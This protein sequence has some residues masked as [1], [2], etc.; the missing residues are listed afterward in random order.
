MWVDGIESP[1]KCLRSE[2]AG[3]FGCPVVVRIAIVQWVVKWGLHQTSKL[4]SKACFVRIY[5]ALS[6]PPL[7]P[8]V[9]EPYLSIVRE[10][11][12]IGIC[13]KMSC[14]RMGSI[15]WNSVACLQH[16]AN[17]FT[18]RYS[19]I[20]SKKSCLLLRNVIKLRSLSA[21]SWITSID[22]GLITGR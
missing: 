20:L 9:L 3:N 5:I 12:R 10:M 7:G 15:T 18:C 21:C 4:G 22:G 1:G 11:T 6:F 16:E 13:L 14:T 8:S 17:Q 2:G 19:S